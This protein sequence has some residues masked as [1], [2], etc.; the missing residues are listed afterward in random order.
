MPPSLSDLRLPPTA[1][2]V[3]EALRAFD[4]RGWKTETATETLV[5]GIESLRSGLFLAESL[6][7]FLLSPPASS[8][9]SE[10]PPAGA[11]EVTLA[12]LRELLERDA[13]LIGRR[14]GAA[15]GART[16]RS[17]SAMA[18]VS[19]ASSRTD[20]ASAG[21]AASVSRG[22]SPGTRAVG[23]TSSP[24]TIDGTSTIKPTAI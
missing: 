1:R 11:I 12:R 2:L 19:C 22:I 4:P 15:L 24:P 17:V 18:V 10:P 23:W 5:M 16:P 14:H 3:G 20:S 13:A 6:P 8:E 9:R 7:L 21:G